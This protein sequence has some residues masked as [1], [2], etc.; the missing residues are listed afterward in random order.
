MVESDFVMKGHRL[1]PETKTKVTV[2]L[3][4]PFHACLTVC[5]CVCAYVS[6]VS[7]VQQESLFHTG[8][9]HYDPSVCFLFRSSRRQSLPYTC[10]QDV[11][12]VSSRLIVLLIQFKA[13]IF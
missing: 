13:V 7:G 9:S 1:G 12:T 5:V 2:D 11:R 6:G 4:L 8:D 10:N 3:K